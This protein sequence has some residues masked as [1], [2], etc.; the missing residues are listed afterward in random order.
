MSLKNLLFAGEQLVHTGYQSPEFLD[1]WLFVGFDFQ[2][3][4]ICTCVSYTYLY[5]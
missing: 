3:N 5:T 1:A 4:D 2:I